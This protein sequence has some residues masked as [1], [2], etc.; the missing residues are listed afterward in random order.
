M[1]KRFEGGAKF[2][3]EEFRL[4]PGREVAAFVELVVMD[5]VGIGPLCPTPRSLVEL[6]WED[7]YGRRNGDAFDSKEGNLVFE[8]PPIEARAADR[9]VCQPGEGDVVQDIVS[10][11]AFALPVK[12]T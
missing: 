4:F 10:G 11:K 7:T 1:T 8:C 2:L 12:H 6:V 9:G 3:T 5:Q